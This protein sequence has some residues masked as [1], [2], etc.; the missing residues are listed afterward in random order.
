M[1]VLRGDMSLV[2]P[3]PITMEELPRYGDAARYY[4]QLRPGMT[5][6]WQVSGRNDTSYEMRVAMDTEYARDI[7]LMGDLS[8]LLRMSGAVLGTTG[9]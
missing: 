6:L 4:L 1:D 8:I 3:R 2:G 9:K 7:T 5:G